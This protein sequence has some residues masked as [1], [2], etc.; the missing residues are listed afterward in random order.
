MS[1]AATCRT[2]NKRAGG[3]RERLLAISMTPSIDFAGKAAY[4]D[5][6]SRTAPEVGVATGFCR[7]GGGPGMPK[8]ARHEAEQPVKA[9]T[10]VRFNNDKRFP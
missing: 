5:R 4:S 6:R 3:E 10:Q 1:V 9:I 8:G 2:L 7:L